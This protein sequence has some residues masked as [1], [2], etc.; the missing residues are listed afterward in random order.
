M[1][2]FHPQTLFEA[3]WVPLGTRATDQIAQ[4]PLSFTCRTGIERT[5][6]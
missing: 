6:R 5:S 3:S 2:A 4:A 1:G